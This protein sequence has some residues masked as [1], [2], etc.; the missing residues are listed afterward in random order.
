MDPA[1]VKIAALYPAPNQPIINGNYPQNDY[2]AVTAGGLRTDQGD[3]RVDYKI[4]D[5]NSLFGSI[6]WSDTSK[7]NTPPFQGALDGGNFYGASENDLGRN[8]QI[9]YTRIWTP[10]DHFG[11]AHC[12]QPPGDRAHAGQRGHRRIQGS[13]AS[14]VWTP[15]PL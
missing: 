6:S 2:Y 8:A 11:N 14:A 13:M 12:L 3:G 4:D 15:P 7:Y 5:K 1:A 9:G 10:I